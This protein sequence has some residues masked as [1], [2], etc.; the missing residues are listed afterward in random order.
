MFIMEKSTM[1][2]STKSKEEHVTE[3]LMLIVE[4][5]IEKLLVME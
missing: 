2:N 3:K 1:E 4:N 5:Q